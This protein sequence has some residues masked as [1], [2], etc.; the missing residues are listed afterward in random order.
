[1]AM[2]RPM[3]IY[4]YDWWPLWRRSALQRRLSQMKIDLKLPK[5]P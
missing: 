4:L 1:V 3:E 2:W 5:A